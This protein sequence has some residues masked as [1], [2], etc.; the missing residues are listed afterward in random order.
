MNRRYLYV[1][2]LFLFNRGLEKKNLEG[3]VMNLKERVLMARKAQEIAFEKK[4]ISLLLVVICGGIIAIFSPLFHQE[5][6][7]PSSNISM[8][9]S[10]AS[11]EDIRLANIKESYRKNISEDIVSSSQLDIHNANKLAYNIVNVADIV[12]IDP[13]LLASVVKAE[14][15]YTHSAENPAGAVGLAQVTPICV[16]EVELRTGVK[17]NRYDEIDNLKVSAIY[18]KLLSQKFQ[19]NNLILAAYNAGETIVTKE[20]KVPDLKETKAYVKKV[21]LHMQEFSSL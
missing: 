12:G 17:Y 13:Y 21:N 11:E 20:N 3:Y 8:K 10:Y 18:L 2:L 7:K 5:Q 4:V 14:S 19:D 6:D 16:K 15:N 1:Y 9:H